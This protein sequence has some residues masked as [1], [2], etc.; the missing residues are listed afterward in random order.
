MERYFAVGLYDCCDTLCDSSVCVYS[1]GLTPLDRLIS[2]N[3]G[4]TSAETFECLLV[5]TPASAAPPVVPRSPTVAPSRTRLNSNLTCHH[6]T[7]GK[8]TKVG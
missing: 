5:L 3:D 4:L 2:Y 8:R 7:P 6:Q 1:L